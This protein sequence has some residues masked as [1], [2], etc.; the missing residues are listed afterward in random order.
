MEMPGT[1]EAIGAAA[2]LTISADGTLYIVDHVDADLR[3]SGGN[4]KRLTP[5]GQVSDLATISDERGFVLPTDVALDAQ[6]NVYVSDRGR[7]EVWRFNPD[8]SGG[9][10]WWTSP[11]V[12]GNVSGYEPNGLAYDPAN[13]AM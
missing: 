3:T 12:T 11:Q 6:G 1:R 5:D 10:V 13:N 9:A 4:I 7:D 2:G 8:G